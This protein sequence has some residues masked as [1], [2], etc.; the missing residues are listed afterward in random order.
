MIVMAK[1]RKIVDDKKLSTQKQPYVVMGIGLFADILII[2]FGLI[3]A[4]ETKIGQFWF[5]HRLL[6]YL[7]GFA[8][9]ALPIIIVILV[10]IEFSREKVPHYKVNAMNFRA[11]L[12]ARKIKSY[13]TNKNLI[14]SLT[15]FVKTKFGYEL[16]EVEI[17]VANDL[18][19][20]LI[21]IENFAVTEAKMAQV[22]NQLSGLLIGKK[23]RRFKVTSYELSSDGNFYVFY[24]EDVV[25]SQRL[26]VINSN[27]DDF[28][29]K[30]VHALRLAKNLVWHVDGDTPHLSIIGRTRSGKSTFVGDYLCP[31]MLKQGWTIE[32]NSPKR[33]V[34][35]RR[36]HGYYDV[37][38]IVHRAEYWL[39]VMDDRNGKIV[40]AYKSKYS[41]MANMPDVAIIFDE[42]ENL[43]SQLENNKDL[44]KRW[45]IAINTLTAS[46][47]S[48][49]IHVIVMSQ[50]ASKEA[51]LPST[52]RSN[53]A[54]AVIMLGLAADSG[55]DRRYLLP[56]FEVPSRNYETGQGL[57]RI[58]SAG[59]KWEQPHY[60]ET[61]L[62]IK[63]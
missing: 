44:K 26:I 40:R 33:D 5:F 19:N 14:D 59:K 58:V 37:R 48:A 29:G 10:V 2:I 21:A 27:V 57:A 8:G 38:D 46:G 30:D 62:L 63:K 3:I 18:S 49:G 51:F 32:Y 42:L 34:Y 55:D 50:M 13:F 12:L 9:L 54:N 47:A 20:G 28:I 15:L 56:G 43:N 39:S 60:F 6:F 4:N 1:F 31:L 24:F 35:V 11:K 22:A 25:T 61:P 41:E 16:P 23:L 17:W 52:A 7:I 45:M 36:Y 53:C